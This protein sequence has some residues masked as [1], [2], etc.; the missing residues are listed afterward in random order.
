MISKPCMRTAMNV[1]YAIEGKHVRPVGGSLVAGLTESITPPMT[2]GVLTE[3][4]IIS[5]SSQGGRVIGT[6]GEMQEAAVKSVADIIGQIADVARNTI[7]PMTVDILNCIEKELS[8]EAANV[9]N[10]SIDIHVIDV[11]EVLTNAMFSSLMEANRNADVPEGTL[12]QELRTIIDACSPADIYEALKTG[13]ASL[14]E[15][16][17]ELVDTYG[18]I[19]IKAILM[20]YCYRLFGNNAGRNWNS[21]TVKGYILVGLFTNGVLNERCDKISGQLELKPALRLAVSTLR[22]Y[23]FRL[24]DTFM[25]EM[26]RSIKAGN[27]NAPTRFFSRDSY[28][29]YMCGPTYRN[30]LKEGGSPEAVIG[31]SSLG[32]SFDVLKEDP[33]RFVVNYKD[34]LVQRERV[35]A[36]RREET[37]R[38]VTRRIIADWIRGDKEMDEAGRNEM[39]SRLNKAFEENQLRVGMSDRCFVMTVLCR[40]Y[41]DGPDV[42]TLLR[43]IDAQLDRMEVKDLKYAVFI[44]HVNL[45]GRWVAS[46]MTVC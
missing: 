23:S 40:V 38:R 20:D 24:L 13:S 32:G 11:P 37:V 19:D 28:R 36:V 42:L 16:V 34:R 12:P 39:R 4:D 45:I 2:T 27:I 14:D 7:N 33:S 8:E 29:V 41:T 3:E 44:A 25:Y 35:M 30:W 15:S 6:H 5:Y 46:Q 26:D 43:D 9:S 18:H 10:Q 21:Q 1:R 22:G 31:W 17:M